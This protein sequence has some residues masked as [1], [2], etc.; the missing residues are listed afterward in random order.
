M[1]GE[2]RNEN[3][4]LPQNIANCNGAIDSH[5]LYINIYT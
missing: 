2:A 5:A 1:A 3:P 4:K